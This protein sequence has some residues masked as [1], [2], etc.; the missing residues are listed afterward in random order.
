MITEADDLDWFDAIAGRPRPGA[1]ARTLLEATLLRAAARAWAPRPLPA[2]ALRTDPE[3]LL[4]RARHEGLPTRG[5]WCAGCAQRW[6]ALRSRP[7][8]GGL[9]LAVAA[10]LA[11]LVFGVLPPLG[12]DGAGD[13]GVLP[14]LRGAPADGVW[15]LRDAEPQALRDRIADELA[16]AGLA[17]HRY[18]R[19]GRFGLD[20]EVP[21]PTSAAVAQALHRHGVQPGPDGVLRIEVEKA[22][23]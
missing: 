8:A 9:G 15:L 5:R 6:R 3:A 14:V 21:A 1:D 18:E 20:A 16:A 7:W 22:A 13:P 11:V 17:A 12:D 10:L 23:P 2:E 4:A 19:L